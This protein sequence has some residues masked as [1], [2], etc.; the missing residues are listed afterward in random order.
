MPGSDIHTA[1]EEWL[2]QL[3]HRTETERGLIGGRRDGGRVVKLSDSIA[4][5]YG[6]RVTNSEAKSQEF[7]RRRVDPKIVHVPRAYRY[8]QWQD[9][10][11][12]APKGY[13]FIEYIP[14]QVL[15]ELDL[16]IHNDIVPRIAGIIA[17][18]GKFK[19]VKPQ[20]P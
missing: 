11:W 12:F 14:G 19:T 5:K 13:L 3:C 15:E 20:A 10:K 4:V 16:K 1:S 18:L 6:H 17:H 8:F 2:V 9:P 7:A